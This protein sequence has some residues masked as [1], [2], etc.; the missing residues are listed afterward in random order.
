MEKLLTVEQL[1]GLI[2]IKRST[3]Y[4]WTH[5]GFIP[6]YKLPKGVRFKEN[7]IDQWLRKRQKKGRCSF[8]VAL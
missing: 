6:H 5:S 4:E 8:K 3:I 1:S 7:E 2:Q